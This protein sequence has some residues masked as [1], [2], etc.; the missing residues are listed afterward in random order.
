LIKILELQ[1]ASHRGRYYIVEEASRKK[2]YLS[3]AAKNNILQYVINKR[4]H[5]LR[6]SRKTYGMGSQIPPHKTF[7]W[8]SRKILKNRFR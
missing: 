2:H 3:A 8:Q 6:G 1:M 5:G 4:I 7:K